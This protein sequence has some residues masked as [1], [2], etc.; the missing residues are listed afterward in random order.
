MEVKR[1]RMARRNVG[2]PDKNINKS[3]TD[4]YTVEF[5]ALDGRKK[6][7]Y[8]ASNE[9]PSV[10]E[11]SGQNREQQPKNLSVQNEDKKSVDSVVDTRQ[12]RHHTPQSRAT[13]KY[14]T[15][16]PTNRINRQDYSGPSTPSS[17]TNTKNYFKRPSTA[18]PISKD[19]GAQVNPPA[20][21]NSNFFKRRPQ[22]NSG[23]H[24][25][26]HNIKRP[27]CSNG[28]CGQ[29]HNQQHQSSSPSVSRGRNFLQHQA[30]QQFNSDRYVPKESIPVSSSSS[31]Q[32]NYYQRHHYAAPTTA[33]TRRTQHGGGRHQ[34]YSDRQ[35]K[36]F[37]I[38][39]LFIF[40]SFKYCSITIYNMHSI[41]LC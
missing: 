3:T 9:S 14:N 30:S 8:N 41:F 1:G 2:G 39:H 12:A 27:H 19:K 7:E 5:P 11:I 25:Q 38:D 20:T 33:G 15:T 32:H 17:S 4:E 37:I 35:C 28:Q 18:S 6:S 34:N 16:S 22:Q 36:Y 21:A 23:G 13:S 31:N 24:N 26:H 40:N 10:V 29:A